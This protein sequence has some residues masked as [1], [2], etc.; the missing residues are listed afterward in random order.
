MTRSLVVMRDWLVECGVTIAARGD[1]P[2]A[3]CHRR[4]A[5]LEQR[6][7]RGR[8]ASAADPLLASSGEGS[9]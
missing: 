3:A 6:L 4:A 1:Q 8:V 2:E 9:R 7:E 5:V